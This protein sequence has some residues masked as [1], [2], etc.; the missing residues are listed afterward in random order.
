MADNPY[1]QVQF[2]LSVDIGSEGHLILYGSPGTGKTTFLQTLIYSLVKN[3]TPDDINIYILDLGGR[4]M[5]YFS[6]LPHV[7]G[8]VY[9][10]DTDKLEKLLRLLNRELEGRKKT[11]SEIGVGNI[12]AYMESTGRKFPL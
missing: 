9:A 1:Q 3:Y 5:G 11:F 2:P 6:E 4:T 8:I 10:D 12:K 7:G